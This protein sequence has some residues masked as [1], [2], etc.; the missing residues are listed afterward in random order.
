MIQPH[1][2]P[3]SC[4]TAEIAGLLDPLTHQQRR[5]LRSY[6]W[7]VELGAQ[8]VSAWLADPQCPVSTKSWY[9]TGE[10]AKYL[11]SPV[12][13]AA[14]DAYRRAGQQ[15][16]IADEARTIAAARR[17][18]RQGASKAASRMVDL[19]DNAKSDAVKLLA[20]Q[21]VL[22]RADA[23]TASKGPTGP[24]NVIELTDD[25]LLAIASRGSGDAGSGGGE[26]AAA[27]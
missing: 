4:E 26:R 23:E 12:F 19:V 24:T 22:D 16:Q 8:S 21:Q 1:A 20:A 27:A 15:W 6:V 7:S 17:T 10:A 18:L 5:T 9:R 11:H 13:R 25:E 3:H 14:L 2:L